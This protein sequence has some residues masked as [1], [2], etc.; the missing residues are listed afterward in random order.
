MQFY[1]KFWRNVFIQTFT[2]IFSVRFTRVRS[3]ER[4]CERKEKKSTFFR[5]IFFFSTSEK[6]PFEKENV[7]LE[8]IFLNL[9][10]FYL[11]VVNFLWISFVWTFRTSG[12]W[13][14]QALAIEQTFDLY[15]VLYGVWGDKISRCYFFDSEFSSFLRIANFVRAVS[16]QA[17]L[18]W[19]LSSGQIAFNWL[20]I[21]SAIGPSI[22]GVGPK[23]SLTL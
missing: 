6:L 13:N 11:I 7:I 21:S 3:S 20:L 17:R 19:S 2:N 16:R 12:T 8:S 14:L 10:L 9:N 1:A 4:S 23:V 5:K 15:F 18:S 22:F